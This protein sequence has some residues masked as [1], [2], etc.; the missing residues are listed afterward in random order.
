MKDIVEIK[1]ERTKKGL[2]N[3]GLRLVLSDKTSHLFFNLFRRDEAYGMI[4]QLAGQAMHRMLKTA[5]SDAPGAANNTPLSL[6]LPQQI[7]STTTSPSSNS[8]SPQ[9][10][11]RAPT[12]TSLPSTLKQTI[13]EQKRNL[14]FQGMFHLPS[15]EKLIEEVRTVFWILD[16]A[17]FGKFYGHLSL[18][19][20]FLCFQAYNRNDCSLV[21]PYYAVRRLER[22]NTVNQV[23]AMTL[24]TCHQLKY[25]FQFGTDR[26][27]IERACDILK[28]RLRANIEMAKRVRH[29]LATST[30]FALLESQDITFGG[31]GLTYG[32]P[33]DAKQNKEKT[34]MKYWLDYF[35]TYGRNVTMI[36]VH[37]FFRLLRIGMPNILR[38][39]LWEVC[40]GAAWER[41]NDPDLYEK[42]LKDHEGRHLI[43]QRRSHVVI[44]IYN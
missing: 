28:D 21:L 33:G 17:S 15:S 19:S 5:S 30:T 25:S 1:K 11:K 36:R 10:R 16:N 2:M 9:V 13:D 39:E 26:A 43:D 24:T 22:F 18:G 31:F 42:L 23:H 7:I 32:F 44:S 12:F 40:S 37:A 38:G 27:I 20:N 14:R 3:D 29:Y 34:K 6:D 4:E 35:R 41:I 8:D